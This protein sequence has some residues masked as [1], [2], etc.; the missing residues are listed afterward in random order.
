MHNL[1][2]FYFNELIKKCQE[3]KNWQEIDNQNWQNMY[4][5]SLKSESAEDNCENYIWILKI[6][7]NGEGWDR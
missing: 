3:T 5:L 6:C 2:K 1:R 4:I 7:K